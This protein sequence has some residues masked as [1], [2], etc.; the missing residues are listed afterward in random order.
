MAE[1]P[2]SEMFLILDFFQILEYLH[3]LYEI[4]WE[5]DP[6]LNRKFI[7]FIYALYT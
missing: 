6:G 1:H 7:C 2:L 3:R 5:W 4:S